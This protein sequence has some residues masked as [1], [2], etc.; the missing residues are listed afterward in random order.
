MFAKC[1]KGVCFPSYSLHGLENTNSD[2]L[3]VANSRS[4][5]F[6]PS[7]HPGP[8]SGREHRPAT[9]SVGDDD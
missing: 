4:E 8:Y 5:G 3:H 2:T 9:F 6:T 1:L 7:R